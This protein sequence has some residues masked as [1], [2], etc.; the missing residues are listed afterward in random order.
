M[1]NNKIYC[2]VCGKEIEYNEN[3]TCEECH[4]KILDRLKNKKSEE[5]NVDINKN[6]KGIFGIVKNTLMAVIL[7]IATISI[8]INVFLIEDVVEKNKTIIKNAYSYTDN[9][10]NYEP[11]EVTEIS[12]AIVGETVQ[13]TEVE[14]NGKYTGSRVNGKKYGTGTYVWANGN[15]YEGEFSDDLMHG[16]GKLNIIGKG[17]YEGDFV[18]GKKSGQGTFVFANGDIYT[19]SWLD[20]K[21]NGDG[22]YTFVNG[23]SYSGLFANNMFNGKGTYYV[24][25]GNSYSGTWSN[26]KYNQ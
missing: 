1:D 7:I 26:N 18:A 8:F 15:T 9:L 13:A 16:K 25:G 6:G 23:D 5:K 12:Q 21:M 20:D 17:T 10:L 24:K 3:E 4:N 14:T 11:T 22:K 19:G 2:K